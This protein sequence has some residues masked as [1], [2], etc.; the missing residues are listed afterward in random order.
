MKI[1]FNIPY[2]CN[3]SSNN[4]EFLVKNPET[5]SDWVFTQK[6]KEYF[7]Q[8]Y[9][10]YTAFMTSSCTRA[11]ELIALSIGILPGDEIIMSSYNFVGVANA[12]SNYGAVLRFTDIDPE[13]MNIPPESIKN[14]INK[15]TRAV[16]V[17]HY[18]SV[19]C[20]LNKIK[21]ICDE[22]DV[23]LIEDNAQ[24]ICAKT[25]DDRLLGSVGD[26]SCI[27]FDTLKNIGCSEGGVLLCKNRYVDKVK[28]CYD[29][30][31]NR[32]A[33]FKKK[34]NAYEWID[35]GSKF[36]MPEFN[37]A[38]LY[39]LLIKSEQIIEERK[40]KWNT[41]FNLMLENPILNKLLPKHQAD[42]KHN[43]HIFFLKCENKRQRDALMSYLKKNGIMNSFHYTP[44]HN[45][46]RG[47]KLNCSIDKDEYTTLESNKLLRLPIY[48]TISD[49]EIKY[50]VSKIEA[51]FTQ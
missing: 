33:F 13:T 1:P 27:S 24:G 9:P 31:T 29:N 2:T 22:S 43:A 20:Q 39:P 15:K 41:Y 40:L 35:S 50:V 11:M 6:C 25:D 12:F 51:Y 8:K 34:V 10:E 16:I 26:F 46:I 42:Y 47:R 44:L 36:N 38:V 21:Q 23:L 17:M 30:G 48:N 7:K 32:S 45:S 14:L 49:E 19:A 4:V 5:I 37:A 18:G 3:D 28:I